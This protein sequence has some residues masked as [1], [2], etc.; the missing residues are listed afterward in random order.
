MKTY[1]LVYI[2]LSIVNVGFGQPANQKIEKAAQRLL[3]DEQMKHALLGF[4]VVESATGKPVCKINEEVGLAPASTQKIFTAIAAFETLGEHYQYNTDIAYNGTLNGNLLKGDLYITGNGDPTLGSWRYPQTKREVVL[5]KI[6]KTIAGAGISSIDG[7]IILDDSRFSYQP[8][9]G[10]WIWDDMGNYYGA[11]CWAVNWNENQ[12]DLNLKPGIKEGDSVIITGTTPELKGAVLKNF[13]K[14]GKP[15]S[16]DNGYIYLA[17]YSTNGFVTG[18]VPAGEKSFKISGSFPLPAYQLAQEL[19]QT[20]ETN[21]VLVKGDVLTS[22]ALMEAGKSLTAPV[23]KIGTLTSPSLDTMA[24]WFLQKSINMYGEALLKTMMLQKDG[25]GSTDGG[26]DLLKQFWSRR[27]ITP[28]SLNILD[29]SGLSPQNRVTP[30]AMVTAM[31][32]A[33]DKPWFKS[34]YNALPLY[35]GM[36]MKSGTIG[37][38]R[39]FTGYHKSVSGKEYSFAIIINNYSGSTAAMVKKIYQLLDELK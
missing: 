21:K 32:Y 13:L 28:E 6:Y 18:T 5:N 11:G 14:T 3:A 8:L 38:A 1:Q 36:K 37:G 25:S 2:L 16:G 39:A 19:K 7:N 12:Y 24:Y 17:P 33:R 27:N 30:K 29:G 26:V 31:Q 20:L 9:P 34:F 35:N 15:G 22:E 23:N 4:Y 10:G